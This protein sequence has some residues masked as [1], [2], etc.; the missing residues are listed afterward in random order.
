M[1]EPQAHK[2]YAMENA[3][4]FILQNVHRYFLYLAFIPLFFLWLDLVPAFYHG[5]QPRIGLGGVVFLV[6]AILLT[7]YSLSCHSLR[8]ILGG[9]LDRFSCSRRTKV[10]Y[11]LCSAPRRS[12]GAT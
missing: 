7:G 12:T 1:G 10:R 9:R 2:R 6:N 11:S 8:H 3:F 4:P 5:G